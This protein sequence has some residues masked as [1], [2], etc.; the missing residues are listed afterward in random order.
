MGVIAVNTENAWKEQ[1]QRAKGAKTPTV[2]EFCTNRCGYCQDMEP[3]VAELATKYADATF[4]KVDLDV[5]VL[6][7]VG[8][9]WGVKGTP[10]FFFLKEGDKVA[11]VE[12]A[13][14]AEVR[15]TADKHLLVPEISWDM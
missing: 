3:V 7:A 15:E 9:E 10:N 8:K 11:K 1:L 6:G 2:V 12:G 13:E 4:L 14:E 5:K